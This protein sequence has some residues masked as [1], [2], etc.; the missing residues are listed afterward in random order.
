MSLSLFLNI[1]SEI[2]QAVNNGLYFSV[3]PDLKNR[4]VDQR[5]TKTDLKTLQ[6][7]VNDYGGEQF[8]L[9]STRYLKAVSS[10]YTKYLAAKQLFKD[11]KFRSSLKL[12]EDSLG[13]KDNLRPYKLLLAGSA[14]LM[15]RDEDKAEGYFKRCMEQVRKN[16]G[17]SDSQQ[18]FNKE[19]GYTYDSC[20]VGLAQFIFKRKIL[21]K[22]KD[23][24]GLLDKSSLIWL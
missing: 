24:Y 12:V 23:L 16:K 5:L 3:I 11:G 18:I 4:I 8:E 20:L 6:T 14:S 2:N 1:E 10:G 9:L 15:T 19:L 21:K 13:Y 22:A 7:I 17:S